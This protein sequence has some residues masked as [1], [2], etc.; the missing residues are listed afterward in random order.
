MLNLAVYKV[1][2][3]NFVLRVPLLMNVLYF[4]DK[5]TN[6]LLSICSVTYCF[7]ATC[8]AHRCY[9]HQCVVYWK[10]SSAPSGIYHTL[11]HSYLYFV[12]RDGDLTCH[13]HVFLKTNKCD[14]TCLCAS[15]S[16]GLS[17]KYRVAQRNGN[18]WKFQHKLKKSKKK[19][20]FTEI[21]PLQLAF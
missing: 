14:W 19:H 21:E 16:V 8:F 3:R 10:S 17:Y 6:A 13:R 9:H 4:Y 5:P 15:A 12:Y 2:A 11:L 20:L 7:S 1:I 18:F